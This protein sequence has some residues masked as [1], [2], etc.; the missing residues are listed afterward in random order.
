MRRFRIRLDTMSDI[1]KFLEISTKIDS[2]VELVD[3][4]GHCVSAKSLL[5]AL[6]SLEWNSIY[7]ICKDQYA[8]RFSEFET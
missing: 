3:N 7:C 1:T 2:K 8:D 5:G 4:D 6:A